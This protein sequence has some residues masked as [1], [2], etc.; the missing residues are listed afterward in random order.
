MVYGRINQLILKRNLWD[1][2]R[3]RHGIIWCKIVKIVKC[4][5]QS[6]SSYG[7]D[8]YHASH[9][10]VN[11]CHYM[12]RGVISSTVCL[13]CIGIVYVYTLILTRLATV[14]SYIFSFLI[15]TL[16]LHTISRLSWLIAW[17]SVALNIQQTLITIMWWTLQRMVPGNS[18]SIPHISSVLHVII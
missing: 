13:I 16:Y 5:W 1:Y 15:N 9:F 10:V 7:I 17:T 11:I 12:D 3:G 14:A 6:P 4:I 2:T 18:I 8:I